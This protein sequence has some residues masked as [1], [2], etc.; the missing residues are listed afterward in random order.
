MWSGVRVAGSAHFAFPADNPTLLQM[1]IRLCGKVFNRLCR[2]V[3]SRLCRKVFSRLCLESSRK[4][5]SRL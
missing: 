3:F 5:F 1:F 2:K 4:V